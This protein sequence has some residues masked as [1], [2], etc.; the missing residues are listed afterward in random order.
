MRVVRIVVNALLATLLCSGG[1]YLLRQESHFLRNRW[2]PEI[3]TYLTGL[4]LSLLALSLFLLAA[5]CAAVMVGWIRGTIPMPDRRENSRHS[6]DQGEILARFWYLL[7]PAFVMI[8]IAFT[9]APTVPNP[10]LD[11]AAHDQ[12][13]EPAIP[14]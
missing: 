3:G 1:V 4:P 14:G 7:I 8:V 5:F 11:P 6:H 10:S 2:N 12:S 13:A 9:L